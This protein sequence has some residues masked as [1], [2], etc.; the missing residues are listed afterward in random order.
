MDQ[1]WTLKLLSST[2]HPPTT[3]NLLTSYRHIRR[4]KVGIQ[5][6]QTKTNLHFYKDLSKKSLKNLRKI[7]RNT[8][9]FKLNTKAS[10]LVDSLMTKATV[11]TPR[12]ITKREMLFCGS[13]WRWWCYSQSSM[14]DWKGGLWILLIWFLLS[15]AHL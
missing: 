14:I 3:L 12:K 5:L 7:L 10:R 9:I 2:T 11:W 15:A 6:N 8:K 1:R 13:S 4:L